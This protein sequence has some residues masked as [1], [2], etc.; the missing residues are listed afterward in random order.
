MKQ[1]DIESEAFGR[2]LNR[3]AEK[4]ERKWRKSGRDEWKF[5]KVAGLNYVLFRSVKYRVSA[6]KLE[7]CY[8]F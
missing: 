1:S 4:A 5:E 6:H 8:D 2:R 3:R 7:D